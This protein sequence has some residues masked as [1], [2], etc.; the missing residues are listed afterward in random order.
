MTGWTGQAHLLADDIREPGF[1]AAAVNASAWRARVDP[2]ATY[3]LIGAAIALTDGDAGSALWAD[4]DPCPDDATLLA[5]VTELEGAVAELLRNASRMAAACRASLEAAQSAAGSGAAALD[6]AH[7][8]AAQAQTA[9]ASAAAQGAIASA[10]A[11]IA[12][13]QAE[14]AD[15]EAA[16]EIIDS[17]GGKLAH[18]LDCLRRVPEDLAATYEEPYDLVRQGG[19]LP[20][21]GDFLTGA[22]A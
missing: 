20:V 8:Q 13:A 6:A 7:G 3:G 16:L 4:A 14:I 22:A 17:A 2:D 18:A 11:A 15:C 9:Q 10:E 19:R 5:A 21:D 12:G 1:G